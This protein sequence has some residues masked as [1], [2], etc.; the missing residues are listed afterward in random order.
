MINNEVWSKRFEE[1]EMLVQ[2]DPEQ[3]GQQ[4]ESL[5]PLQRVML[6][7][8]KSPTIAELRS[9]GKVPPVAHPK[10]TGEIRF[11]LGDLQGK[12]NLVLRGDG[13]VA[14]NHSKAGIDE[15]LP[16]EELIR[17]CQ[18]GVTRR[19]YLWLKKIRKNVVIDRKDL[20][21]FLR[22]SGLT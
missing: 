9:P 15:T 8:K 18:D 21:N 13:N 4:E 11:Q 1:V 2:A 3:S 16:K 7:A 14:I 5:T 20:Q 12:L 19:V 6:W 17:L 10:R 22:E